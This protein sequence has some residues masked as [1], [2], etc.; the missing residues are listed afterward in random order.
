MA[1]Q[2]NLR[3]AM[4]EMGIE[5]AKIDEILAS[6]SDEEA[7]AKANLNPDDYKA[8]I[9]TLRLAS[10]R[11]TDWRKKAAIAARIISLGLDE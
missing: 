9:E 1:N 6:V 5:P 11:E 8:M 2:D 10:Y 3:A 4:E 7:A